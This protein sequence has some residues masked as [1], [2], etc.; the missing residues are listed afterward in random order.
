MWT[1]PPLPPPF[2][3]WFS[4]SRAIV[5]LEKQSGKRLEHLMLEYNSSAAMLAGIWLKS[6]NQSVIILKI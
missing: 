2:T 3:F 6:S 4:E 1:P 5:C